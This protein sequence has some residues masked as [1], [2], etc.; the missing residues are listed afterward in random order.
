MMTKKVWLF[1]PF[2][3]ERKLTDLNTVAGIT[4]RTINSV[5]GS[6]GC[7]LKILNCYLLE[8]DTPL[9]AFRELLAK[10]IIP[11]EVW[12][13]IP[14]S[15]WQV[16]S[17]GRYRSYLRCQPDRCVYRLPY[18]GTKSTSQ[19]M[20]IKINGKRQEFRAQEWVYKL[21]VGEVPKGHVIYH[22]DGNKANNRVENLGVIKR[23][24]LMQ[25]QCTPVRA[26]EVQQIDLDTGEILAEYSTLTQ[27]AK[28]NF[29]DVKSIREAARRG[30]SSIGFI[31]KTS[32]EKSI[33]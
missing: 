15:L 13:D 29:T 7:K 22:K 8:L 18:Y 4:G 28:A 26:V 23:S 3:A 27:A 31:W 10:Q 25:I 33:I 19:T 17:Y 21:F 1:D 32:K 30:K 20:A 9:S 24:K 12:R 11:D 2:T 6:I 16:S 14:N 5:R